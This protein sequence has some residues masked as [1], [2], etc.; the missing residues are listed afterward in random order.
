[1]MFLTIMGFWCLAMIWRFGWFYIFVLNNFCTRQ[2]TH[3]ELMMSISY[4]L[5]CRA[6]AHHHEDDLPNA[7][8]CKEKMFINKVDK[9]YWWISFIL[10]V[11]G[12]FWFSVFAKKKIAFLR[13][14]ISRIRGFEF[15]GFFP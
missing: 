3:Q 12:F 13:K 2:C 6:C 14:S 5:F 8:H 10:I 4:F 7:P 1:M 15:Y 11:G 9:L